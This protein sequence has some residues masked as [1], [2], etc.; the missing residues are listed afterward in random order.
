V[1]LGMTFG[2]LDSGISNGSR[3]IRQLFDW[4]PLL[5]SAF[6][7]CTSA[8]C[9]SGLVWDSAEGFGAAIELGNFSKPGQTAQKIL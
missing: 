9:G 7:C 2:S 4:P 8:D 6:P 3:L 5:E 1:C